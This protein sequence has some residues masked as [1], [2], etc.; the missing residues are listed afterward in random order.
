MLNNFVNEIKQENNEED[1]LEIVDN[2]KQEDEGAQ[3]SSSLN[4]SV[5]IENE[6]YNSQKH[7][8]F[9]DVSLSD[10]VGSTNIKQEVKEEDPLRLVDDLKEHIKSVH[11]NVRYNCDKCGKSFSQ[12]G[13]LNSHIQGVHENIRYNCEKCDKSYS[14]KKYLYTHIKRT[15]GNV[16]HTCDKCDKSFSQ[17]GYLN[18]HIQSVHEHIRYKCDKCDNTFS[19]KSGLKTHVKSVHENFRYKCEKCNRGFTR[20]DNLKFHINAALNASCDEK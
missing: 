15:H 9:V 4:Q 6:Q 1:L 11:E 16:R 10:V 14:W 20:K 8:N 17:K 12:K 3:C 2:L 5:K 7:E 13:T 18:I 19:L